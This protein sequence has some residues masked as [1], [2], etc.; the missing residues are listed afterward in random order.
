MNGTDSERVREGGFTLVEV[1]VS[2]ALISLITVFV[3][4][5][6]DH[7]RRVA[8]LAEELDGAMSLEAVRSYLS[9]SL[10]NAHRPPPDESLD[11][12]SG[13]AG[14]PSTLAF[15]A[16]SDGL[17]D[18]G[19]LYHIALS[20]GMGQS[21][22]TRTPFPDV[23]SGAAAD[24]TRTIEARGLQLRYWGLVDGEEAPR[25]HEAWSEQTNLPV[26]VEVRLEP[27]AGRAV[28]PPLVVRL[29]QGG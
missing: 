3:A 7:T 2:L 12:A 14:G 18:S 11:G 8:A 27:T 1:L 20:G 19:G 25:W 5:G 10:A 16:P 23:P 21:T 24:R 17:L 6:F 28:W 29:Y 26:L 9:L 22:L 15:L 4:N 13:F